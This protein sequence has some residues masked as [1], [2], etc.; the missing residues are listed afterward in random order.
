MYFGCSV[1]PLTSTIQC[2]GGVGEMGWGAHSIGE[3]MGR[4][5]GWGEGEGGQHGMW[6][7]VVGVQWVTLI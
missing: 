2:G 6:W 3:N 1:W 4:C 7:G 5:R